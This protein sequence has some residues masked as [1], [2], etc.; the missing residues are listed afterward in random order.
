[1]IQRIHCHDQETS[2]GIFATI[3]EFY[4]V[5][6]GVIERDED[7]RCG[8]VSRAFFIIFTEEDLCYNVVL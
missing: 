8:N 5:F 7:L 1:M 3:D 2:V 4:G 6:R